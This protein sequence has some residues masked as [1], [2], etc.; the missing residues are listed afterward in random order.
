MACDS[1]V[2]DNN[3]NGGIGA[4]IVDI[5]FGIGGEGVIAG[6]G[7]KE[8]GVVVVCAEG[9]IVHGPKPVTRLILA[10][11][12][13]DFFGCGWVRGFD[14]IERLSDGDGVVCTLIDNRVKK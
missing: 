8:D 7:Q 3:P 11:V 12:D 2:I 1:G 5:P 14:G 13:V 4:E 10:D 6:S 9:D